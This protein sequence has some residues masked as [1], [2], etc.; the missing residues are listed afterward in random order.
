MDLDTSNAKLVFDLLDDGDGKLSAEEVVSG[1]AKLRG[2]A[3]SLDMVSLLK[4]CSEIDLTCRII[5]DHVAHFSLQG[6]RGT[7][8][9]KHN[10]SLQE[11]KRFSSK[12]RMLRQLTN[13]STSTSRS[14]SRSK[15]QSD[16]AK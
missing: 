10:K 6:G 7:E 9:K 11:L 1:V 5:E 3:R 4:R 16:I 2:N 8:R 15:S 13:R 14:V 12:S